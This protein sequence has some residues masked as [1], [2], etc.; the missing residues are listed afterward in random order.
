M[1]T[2]Q[3]K[4]EE[5]PPLLGDPRIAEELALLAPTRRVPLYDKENYLALLARAP[6]RAKEIELAIPMIGQYAT[7]Y[8][9]GIVHLRR[10]SKQLMGA[11]AVLTRALAMSPEEVRDSELAARIVTEAAEA[12]E[13]GTGSTLEELE[14][15]A[16]AQELLRAIEKKQQEAAVTILAPYVS[17]TLLDLVEDCVMVP[18]N[19]KDVRLSVALKNEKYAHTLPHWIMPSLV[20]AWVEKSFGTEAK[21]RPW[22]AATEEALSRMV[23]KKVSLSG[24]LSVASSALGSLTETFSTPGAKAGPTPDGVTPS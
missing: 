23:G 20:T 9:V 21:W 12:E 16:R 19:G 4:P 2:E 7:V 11:I 3:Q 5:L 17:T 18:V 1:T 15:V 8:P 24:A 22:I 14:Q 13:N 10:F 6:E